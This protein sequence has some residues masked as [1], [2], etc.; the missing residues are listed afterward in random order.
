MVR[1]RSQRVTPKQAGHGAAAY[2]QAQLQ[3]F[4]PGFFCTPNADSP[5]PGEG[6]SFGSPQLVEVFRVGASAGKS[7]VAARAR[8]ATGAKCLLARSG[9]PWPDASPQQGQL[10][11]TA[12]SRLPV[13]LS[14]QDKQLLAGEQKLAVLVA[15][16]Q[17]GQQ[18]VQ[19]RKKEQLEVVDHGR[20]GGRGEEGGQGRRRSR[21]RRTTPSRAQLEPLFPAPTDF[22]P[23]RATGN[24]AFWSH[25]ATAPLIASSISTPRRLRREPSWWSSTTATAHGVACR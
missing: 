19:G 3:A 4:R 7:S 6:S 18:R 8:G 20:K 21:R 16:E 17:D 13:Q 2:L 23:L 14:M 1:W 5:E 22:G 15:P 10:L 25:S 11:Q 9:G 12:V 24:R